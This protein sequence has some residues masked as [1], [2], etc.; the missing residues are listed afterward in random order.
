MST[1]AELRL[2]KIDH[3]DLVYWLSPRINLASNTFYKLSEQELDAQA[4]ANGLLNA[5][6]LL[7]P[8]GRAEVARYR[9]NSPDQDVNLAQVFDH[10]HA[11][12]L[13]AFDLAPVAMFEMD[14]SEVVAD[15]LAAKISSG[16]DFVSYLEH[17]SDFLIEA[18]Q[19][20]TTYAANNAAVRLFDAPGK[21]QLL[22]ELHRV[23]GS[24]ALLVLRQQLIA[25]AKDEDYWEGET[26]CHTWQGNPLNVLLRS[27]FIINQKGDSR[28][29][30]CIIDI[31]A[32]KQAEKQLAYLADHDELT[33]LPNRSAFWD[34]LNSGIERA[35]RH[36]WCLALLYIDLDGFKAVNDVHGHLVG[37]QLLQ[38]VGKRLHRCARKTDSVA[39]Y[40]G[41]EF[42]IILEAMNPP[43]DVELFAKKI[44]STIGRPV[45]LAGRW[46]NVTPSIGIA[47]YPQNGK[48]PRNLVNQAD[49]AMY[50]AK[51]TGNQFEICA[52]TTN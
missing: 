51:Q 17:H 44:L 40:G 30:V 33:G 38:Q 29:L 35:K 36:S 39:R 45:K 42:T 27:S 7:T 32:R 10:R 12:R 37:D 6:G 14:I 26:H 19:K 50:R 3:D 31:T 23:S 9:L 15:I 20:I 5:S 4:K 24:D 2:P 22:K 43:G 41:D 52:A 47:I 46:V 34:Q 16:L 8:K 1:R 18:S 25:I 11:S 13:A 21:P 28:M 49:S 48:D